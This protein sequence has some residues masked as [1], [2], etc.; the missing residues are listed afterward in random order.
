MHSQERLADQEAW[1]EAL[2]IG[3]TMFECGTIPRA[4][5]HDASGYRHFEVRAV[6]IIPPRRG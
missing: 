1:R 4:H 6:P 3:R 5:T 2:R